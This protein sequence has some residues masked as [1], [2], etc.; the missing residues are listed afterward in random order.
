MTAFY[1][2]LNVITGIAPIH[3]CLSRLLCP[4]AQTFSQVLDGATGKTETMEQRSIFSILI[5]K[6]ILHNLLWLKQKILQSVIL[7]ASE[8]C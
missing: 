6:N 2:G 1:L 5:S 7:T 3:T 8:S 4:Q